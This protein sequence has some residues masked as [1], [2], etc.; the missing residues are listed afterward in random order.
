MPGKADRSG[1]VQPKEEDAHGGILLF[2]I[3]T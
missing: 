2:Y 1:A 3:G